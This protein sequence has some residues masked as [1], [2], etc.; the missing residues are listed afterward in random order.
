MGQGRACASCYLKDLHSLSLT[1]RAW[2]EAANGAMYRKVLVLANEEHGAH[3]RLKINGTS[4]LK[5]LRKT[6]R[7]SS[8]LAEQVRE[9]HLPAFQMLYQNATIEQEEIVNLVA[10]LVMAC[11]RLERLV[12][13]HVPFSNAFDRLSYALSM[14]SNLKERTWILGSAENELNEEDEDDMKGHYI[15][16]CD[17]TER[18]L[19]LNSNHPELSTL[20]LHQGPNN[21]SPPLNFRAIVGTFRSFPQLRH[22][23]ICGLPATS[24][25]NMVLNALPTNLRSLRLEK[26][27]GVTEKGIQRFAA[28]PQAVSIQK[29]ALISLEISSVVTLG[30]ILSTHLASL[31]E[32]SLVQ[33]K[34]PT[35]RENDS[36]PVF[37]SPS[38]R[39]L[40]W[41]LR[42][43]ASSLPA[44][45]SPS[46]TTESPGSPTSYSADLEPSCCIS[47]SILAT[48]IIDNGFPSLRRIRIP[49]DPQGT[50]Q[51]LCK[52]LATALIQAD[53]LKLALAHRAGGLS[54]F[55]VDE[56]VSASP[57]EDGM[58]SCVLVPEARVDSVVSL[59]R[60]GLP[61]A[62]AVIDAVLT[63]MRSRIAAQSRILAARKEAG[64]VVRVIDPD[65]NDRVDTIFGSY[66]GHLGS[67]I[68]YELKPDRCVTR[69]TE[70]VTGMEDLTGCRADQ[71]R[72]A[73]ECAWGS[74]GHIDA[75]GAGG[76]MVM[77]DDL[78]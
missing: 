43:E 65:G 9:L 41:E 48:S 66:I 50:I 29:L 16:E 45:T 19:D 42:S 52:P 51:S 58:S 12:G 37:H 30:G 5:L 2:G 36:T 40:H 64:M 35:L 21:S 39:Y 1:S 53:I 76:K 49:H 44:S 11:P 13:F 69:R 6:L 8:A 54:S 47:T 46:P 34:A 20:V 67:K 17:P 31:E 38:L 63:P 60:F 74:C 33:N 61:A 25:T 75:T 55:P 15:A 71:D 28:S 14:R 10:S 18:F 62:N 59:P 72:D 4:R 32:F 27:P 68:T 26:L 24:F 22:L 73:L 77:V 57:Q 3:P 78:F 7:E 23:S 70:W 56:S